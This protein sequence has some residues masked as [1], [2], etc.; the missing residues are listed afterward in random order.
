MPR[1]VTFYTT[2]NELLRPLHVASCETVASPG[3]LSANIGSQPV[4]LV[5][6][7]E[8]TLGVCGVKARPLLVCRADARLKHTHHTISQGNY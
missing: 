5:G 7:C 2:D 3:Q 1:A 6:C 8:G 4:V